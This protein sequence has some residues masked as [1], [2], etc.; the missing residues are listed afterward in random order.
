IPG[1]LIVIGDH[2]AFPDNRLFEIYDRTDG[3]VTQ[4]H[5][6]RGTTVDMGDGTDPP[7]YLPAN[8]TYRVYASRGT[9]WSVASAA[10]SGTADVDLTFR[11]Q[12]VIDT[13]GYLAS[14]WHVH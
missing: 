9:E 3:V 12:R 4:V 2:P 14:D 8:G 1:T 5:A 10:V 11:L 13:Q 6:I 7:L